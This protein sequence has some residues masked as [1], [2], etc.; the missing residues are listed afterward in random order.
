MCGGRALLEEILFAVHAVAS[1]EAF[2]GQLRLT[3]AAL[4]ALAVP[5]AVQHFEDEA[6]HDVLTAART[7]GDLCGRQ[8]RRLNHNTCTSTRGGG[9]DAP[10]SLKISIYGQ[11]ITQKREIEIQYRI[12]YFFHF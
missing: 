8:E 11:L 12:D 10:A 5:V 9:E 2:L 6:V 4:Q 3:V 1:A 7:H